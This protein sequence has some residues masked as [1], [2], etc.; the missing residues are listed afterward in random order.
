MALKALLKKQLSKYPPVYRAVLRVY[1]LLQPVH[2]MELVAGTRAREREWARRTSKQR[3]EASGH[4][5]DEWIMGYWDTRNQGHRP[6]MIDKI[7]AHYP[8][9]SVLEIGCNC[10]PNLYMLARKFPGVRLEGVDINEKAVQTGNELLKAEGLSNV[11]LWA[12]KADD[13]S[14]FSDGSFDITFSDAVLILV[15]RD[16]IKKVAREMLRVTRRALVL[17][18]RHCFEPQARDPQGL[19]V[20]RHGYWERDY[21]ALF[22]QFVPEK[23][24]V[25][26]R[27]TKDIWPDPRWQE[28]GAVIEVSLNAKGTTK[29]SMS[30]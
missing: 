11:K 9:S 19:G 21:T 12:G 20:Y 22:R 13:L 28:T 18:E 16:K 27:I 26:T 4:Q 29:M 25:I 6:F 10:G 1:F 8:F 7:S 15:G 5:G 3:T 17:L 23:S 30:F 14:Q 24:I 2:L